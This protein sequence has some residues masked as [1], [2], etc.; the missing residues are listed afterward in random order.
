MESS[1]RKTEYVGKAEISSYICL[2]NQRS[3]VFDLNAFL[4][5]RYLPEI[6]ITSIFMQDS[7]ELRLLLT[8]TNQLK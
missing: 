7:Y 3:N 5:C 4:G 6:D 2:N 1:L 8:E